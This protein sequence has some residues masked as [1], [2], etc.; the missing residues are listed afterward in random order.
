MKVLA[1]V[2]AEHA[3]NGNAVIAHWFFWCCNL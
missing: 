2:A 3:L 1:R